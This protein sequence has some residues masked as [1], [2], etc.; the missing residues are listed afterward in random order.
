MHY[1][2]MKI[3]NEITAEVDG[4]IIEVLREDED[5]VEFGMELFKIV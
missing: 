1:E 3:M 2:A 4:K 5:I